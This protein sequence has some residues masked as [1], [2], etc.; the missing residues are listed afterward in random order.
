MSNNAKLVDRA[1]IAEMIG[2]LG[3]EDLI[4]LNRVIIDRL[5]LIDQAK[6]V[7]LMARFYVG[8]KVAFWDQDGEYHMG[9]II[10]LNQKTASIHTD[11]GRRWKVSPS[12]LVEMKND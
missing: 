6:S 2:H 3:E 9:T 1:T 7:C 4:F 8:A 5:H 11:D 10:K 12:L